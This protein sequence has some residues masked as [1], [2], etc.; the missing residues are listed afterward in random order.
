MEVKKNR[1][2]YVYPDGRRCEREVD[3]RKGVAYCKEH[4]K[5]FEQERENF[6]IKLGRVVIPPQEEE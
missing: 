2:L 5:L 6:T 1:C 3:Y 4:R